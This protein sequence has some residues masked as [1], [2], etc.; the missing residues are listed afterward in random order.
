VGEK[1]V[2]KLDKVNTEVDDI[3][4][5]LSNEAPALLPSFVE[6]VASKRRGKERLDAVFAWARQHALYV[7]LAFS[8]S[9]AGKLL[10]LM[11]KTFAPFG[12][13]L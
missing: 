4:D 5:M 13:T 1:V 6:D 11:G 10:K 9:A 7:D 12:E 8:K 2:I 3:I